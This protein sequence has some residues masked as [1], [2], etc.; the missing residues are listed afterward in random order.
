MDVKW[1]AINSFKGNSNSPILSH[2][3][4]CPVC[5]SLSLREVWR[6]N[7]FQFFSDSDVVPK[8]FDLR[9]VQCLD[10]FCLYSNPC[11]SELGTKYLFNEIE[12]SYGS[13][14]GRPQEQISWLSDRG[15]ISDGQKIMDIGC[16]DGRLL[17][18]IN[19][20]IELKKIGVD[21]DSSAIER[22]RQKYGSSGICFVLG[23]FDNFVYDDVVDVI[24][25][26]HVLEHLLRPVET[27]K[28]LRSIAHESTKL[29]IEVPILENGRFTN[30]INGFFSAHHLTHFSLNSLKDC[31]SRSGWDVIE[32]F[33]NLPYNGC[34]LL[35]TPRLGTEFAKNNFVDNKNIYLYFESWYNSL[36]KVETALAEIENSTRCVVWGAGMHTEYLYN[37]TSFFHAPINREYILVDNDPAKQ[38]KSWRGIP[39]YNP[40]V[41]KQLNMT[42]IPVLIS[43]YG[44]QEDIAN[45][46]VINDLVKNI[47]RLYI[48]PN[49]Y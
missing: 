31:L 49:V 6:I 29:I 8:R 15:L 36:Q 44:N 30:D 41:L 23:N 25:M 24:T 39:V 13:S 27:L 4:Q 43:S 28:K 37:T 14:E 42:D 34:R 5:E 2:Y 46:L 18:L 21:I 16:N 10:C 11:I 19:A 48:E 22:G 32:E 3:R 26:F 33:K 38:G 12:R 45:W 7:D 35:C 47:V 17:S 40:D 20:S 9:V 1:S